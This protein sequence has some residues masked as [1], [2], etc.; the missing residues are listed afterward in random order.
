MSLRNLTIAPRA[1]LGFGLGAPL[2]LFLGASSRLQ[3]AEMRK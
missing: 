3:R 1:A 2:V